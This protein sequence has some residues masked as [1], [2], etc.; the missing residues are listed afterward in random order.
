MPEAPQ[1]ANLQKP[2]HERSFGEKRSDE[3]LRTK[4]TLASI[5]EI[6]FL[7]L[8]F[9]V[10]AL[11][12]AFTGRIKE[13]FFVPEWSIA[14][15]VITGQTVV[16]IVTTALGR[17]A[18]KEAVVTMVCTLVVFLLV[19]SLVTLGFVLE[20]SHVSLSLAITQT[21]LFFIAATIFSGFNYVLH[22]VEANE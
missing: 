19:P 2:E 21:L 15:P 12:L 4:A 6:C 10:I 5:S 20:A 16:R 9:I 1:N 22:I 18:H 14:T 11:V 13:F 7:A 17:W 8:P 3:K